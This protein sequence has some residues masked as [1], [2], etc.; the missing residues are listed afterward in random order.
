MTLIMSPIE[1]GYYSYTD[2]KTMT[3]SEVLE[4]VKYI[5][6]GSQIESDINEYHESRQ[7]STPI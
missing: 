2:L 1:K 6:Y 7:N 3:I 5:D 4:V